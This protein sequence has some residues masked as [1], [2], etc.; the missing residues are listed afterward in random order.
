ML[1]NK[2]TVNASPLIVTVN[3]GF[4]FL[5]EK[6]FSEILISEAVYKEISLASHKDKT[7]EWID[8]SVI[9]RKISVTNSSD[10]L[11]WNLGAG[12]TSVLSY[13]HQNKEY[14]AVLDD[15][16]AKKCAITFNIPVLGTGS[17]LLVAKEFGL[18]ANVRTSLHA[19]KDSGMWISD[20]II[21]LISKKAGE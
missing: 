20:S 9:I 4:S 15:L 6:L 19:L 16:S 5:W 13:C 7:K 11:E 10:I 18:I 3:S 2:I 17:L 12:E 14:T 8:S 1:K 21:E